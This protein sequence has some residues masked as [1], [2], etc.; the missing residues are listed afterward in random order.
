MRNRYVLIG[1]DCI[2]SQHCCFQCGHTLLL[3]TSSTFPVNTFYNMMRSCVTVVCKCDSGLTMS[4]RTPVLVFQCAERHVIC[5]ECF[6]MYCVTRLNERQFIQ[7]PLVGYSLPCAGKHLTLGRNG[8]LGEFSNSGSDS[9]STQ[10]ITG[11]CDLIFD[12][13]IRIIDSGD[14]FSSSNIIIIKNNTHSF[15]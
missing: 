8:S 11:T 2:T 14:F 4:S 9:K 7:E 5:L 12:F 3:E 10:K 15:W 13:V 6:H 1:C